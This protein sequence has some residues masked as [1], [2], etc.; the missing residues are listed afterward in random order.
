MCACIR[1]CYQ[2][3]SIHYIQWCLEQHVSC[4]PTP[5]SICSPTSSCAIDLH[6]CL[7]CLASPVMHFVGIMNI[8]TI[9]IIIMIEKTVADAFLVY[10]FIK[11]TNNQTITIM[12]KAVAFCLRYPLFSGS[13]EFNFNLRLIDCYL[14]LLVSISSTVMQNL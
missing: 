12:K 3:S 8:P 6:F 2:R 10:L 1:N 14:P 9:I 7:L 13:L 5:S 4:P 11:N